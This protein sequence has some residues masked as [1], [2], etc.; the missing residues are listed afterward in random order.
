MTD[1]DHPEPLP[2]YY[3]LRR[4]SRNV[5]LADEPVDGAANRGVE[6]QL[7]LSVAMRIRKNMAWV[8]RMSAKN[9]IRL[10]ANPAE[11]RLA[12]VS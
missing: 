11:T 9:I 12:K 2:P 6:S 1:D 4:G 8:A 10:I 3:L 7:R 5:P